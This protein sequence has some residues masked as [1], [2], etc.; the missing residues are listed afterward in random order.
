MAFDN[1]LGDGQTDPKAAGKSTYPIGAVESVKQS[2]Q[3]QTVY[4]SVGILHRQDGVPPLVE[5][6]LNLAS[7]IA[8]FY[9]VVQQNSSQLAD[10]RFISVVREGGGNVTEKDMV[11]GACIIISRI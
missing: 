2:L 9:R 1:G 6:D 11:P 4:L 3:L 5:P 10:E 8:V 7:G